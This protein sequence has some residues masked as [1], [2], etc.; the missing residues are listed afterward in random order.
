MIILWKR[1]RAYDF[2]DMSRFGYFT[3]KESK[4]KILEHL[5]DYAIDWL[6]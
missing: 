5:T 1:A 3:N 6:I 2:K 4:G